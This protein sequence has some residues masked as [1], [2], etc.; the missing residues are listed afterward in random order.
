M[1]VYTKLINVMLINAEN[2]LWFVTPFVPKKKKFE[3][4]SVPE[5]K[6]RVNRLQVIGLLSYL[7]ISGCSVSFDTMLHMAE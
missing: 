3:R 7:R 2:M 4:K 6:M 5:S 1:V